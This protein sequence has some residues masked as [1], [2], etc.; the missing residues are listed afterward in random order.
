MFQTGSN[1][2]DEQ[3]DTN[4]TFKLRCKN[5]FTSSKYV[6][7]SIN[8]PVDYFAICQS[9]GAWEYVDGNVICMK[10]CEKPRD[11][12]SPANVLTSIV[13]DQTWT[14]GSEF[15][16]ICVEGFSSNNLVKVCVDGEWVGD[17]NCQFN[18]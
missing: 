14:P 4:A 17:I 3:F 10:N 6:G 8:S 5:D 12:I 16:Y 2:V 11:T 18:I 7:A 15:N 1:N 9:N 13:P